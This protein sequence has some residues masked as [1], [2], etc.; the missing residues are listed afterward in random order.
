M[1]VNVGDAVLV[2]LLLD[3]DPNLPQAVGRYEKPIGQFLRP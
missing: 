2:R 1:A 3:A